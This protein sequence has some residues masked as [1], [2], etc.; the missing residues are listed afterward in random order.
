MNWTEPGKYLEPLAEQFRMNAD[1]KE[2]VFMKKYMRGQYDYYG[3]KTPLRRELL[4]T[5]LSEYGLPPADHTEAL[6]RHCWKLNERDYQYV[7]MEILG[8]LIKRIAPGFTELFDYMILTKSWWDT[9]DYIAGHLVGIHFK[10]YPEM[11][12]PW[13]P[14]WMDSDNIWLQR[15]C[16]LFQLHYKQQTDTALMAKCIRRLYGSG[17]FFINKAI[18]W[19]LREY[20]K[21]DA[22]WVL[23]FVKKEPLAP[24]SRREAL[25]WLENRSKRQ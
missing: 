14:R 9:V 2:A 19:A 15:T 20:S 4:R 6:V 18:G 10:R 11:I 23:Q 24:L 17:E 12:E 1:Q 3:I 13:I 5:F 25:K 22:Q 7:A 8:R 16:M 21:T